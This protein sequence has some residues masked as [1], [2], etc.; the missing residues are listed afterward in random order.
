MANNFVTEIR[1]VYE[2]IRITF[3]QPERL[4][5]TI[6]RMRIAFRMTETRNTQSEYVTLI[7]LPLQMWLCERAPGLR[8]TY[9]ACLV[10][11]MSI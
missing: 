5:R 3:L 11:N 4:K 2:K 1:A 6:W 8:Y 7:A 9:I 10:F